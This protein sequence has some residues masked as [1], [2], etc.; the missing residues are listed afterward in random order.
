MPGAAIILT[1]DA[2]PKPLSIGAE[3]ITVLAAKESTGSYEVFLQADELGAGPPPHHHA[4][5]EAFFVIAGEFEFHLP[6][7][8]V[9]AKVG[10]FCHIPAG[11]S[12]WFR[13][14][15]AG[16]K[17]ISITSGSTAAAM[18]ADLAAAA[19][20]FPTDTEKVMAA[21]AKHGLRSG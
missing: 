18:F 15:A 11:T 9:A 16:S 2:Y 10:T 8:T 5:D 21:G 17:M 12:H 20:R 13:S 1:P 4:W 3:S 7:R 14:L 6:D 19:A